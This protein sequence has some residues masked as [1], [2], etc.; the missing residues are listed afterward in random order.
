MRFSLVLYTKVMPVWK[1]PSYRVLHSPKTDTAFILHYHARMTVLLFILQQETTVFSPFVFFRQLLRPFP[2]FSLSTYDSHFTLSLF[3]QITKSSRTSSSS[4]I[5]LSYFTKHRHCVLY[6]SLFIKASLSILSYLQYREQRVTRSSYFYTF[7]KAD[8]A[9]FIFL[10]IYGKCA[11]Y[12]LICCRCQT[13]T[14]FPVIWF[15]HL[16]KADSHF[17]SSFI[18]TK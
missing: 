2:L 8:K 12:F 5:Y 18:F 10:L 14:A 16:T 1:Q 4:F 3:I 9:T 13:D 11:F 7:L 15:C 6:F 17:C